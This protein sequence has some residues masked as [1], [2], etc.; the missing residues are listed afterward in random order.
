MVAGVTYTW[1]HAGSSTWSTALTGPPRLVRLAAARLMPTWRFRQPGLNYTVTVASGTIDLSALD[2]GT[3][4]NA[5]GPALAITSARLNTDTL[6]YT[7][8][9]NKNATNITINGGGVFD[10]RSTIA[11]GNSIAETITE[12]G[13]GGGGQADSRQHDTRPSTA[14]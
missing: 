8:A 13:M 11:D 1:T 14:T 4:T 6:D 7:T 12:S 9:S 2:I 10:V 5:N 3:S